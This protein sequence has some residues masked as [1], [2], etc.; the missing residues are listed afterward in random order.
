MVK[1]IK[2]KDKAMENTI[3]KGENG[4]GAVMKVNSC[5]SFETVTFNIVERI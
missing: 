1:K 2:A 5:G 3:I 4:E